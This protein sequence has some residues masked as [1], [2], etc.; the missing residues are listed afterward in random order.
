[1]VVSDFFYPFSMHSFKQ[2]F[3]YDIQMSIYT[4]RKNIQTTMMLSDNYSD[5]Y[6]ENGFLIEA[7]YYSF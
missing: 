7:H 1:M 4:I 2:T 6:Y 5:N 3:K